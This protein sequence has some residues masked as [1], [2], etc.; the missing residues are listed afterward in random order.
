MKSAAISRFVMVAA[1]AALVVVAGSTAAWAQTPCPASPNYAT[2]F[3]SRP[4]C[5]QPNVNASVTTVLQLTANSGNQY[6]SAW[7]K[8]PQVVQNGFTTSFQFQFSTTT[9]PAD[10]IAF[11]IQNAGTGAIGSSPNGGA[12]GYGDSDN[13]ADPSQGAGIPHSLAIE[14]DSFHNGWDPATDPNDPSGNVSH[15]A[16]QSCGSGPNTSHH[17]Q[18]CNLGDNAPNSTVGAPVLVPALASTGSPVGTHT[19]TITYAPATG[20]TSANIHVMLD[21]HDL[22][23]GGVAVDLSSIGLGDGGTA[24]VGFTGATGG[25]HESQVVQNWTFTPQTQV[26]TQGQPAVYS[27][28]GGFDAGGFNYNAQLNTGNPVSVQVVPIPMT[29]GDCDNLVHATPAF[30]GAHCFV[31]DKGNGSAPAAVIFEITCPQSSGQKCNSLDALLGSDFNFTDANNPGVIGNLTPFPG[32]LKGDGLISGH[33]CA[34]ASPGAVVFNS[35]Q[36]DSFQI[37]AGDPPSKTKGGSG[38]TGS[39]WVA[40]YNQPDETLP[41][42]TF[43]PS[44]NTSYAQG[45]SPVVS[46]TC[47]NPSSSKLPELPASNPVGPYLTTA[48]CQQLSGSRISCSSPG[49]GGIACTGTLDTSTVGPHTFSVTAVDSGTNTNTQSVPYTVVAPADLRI[50]KSALSK[51]PVNSNLTYVITLVNRNSNPNPASA[52]G[53]VVTDPLPPNT[54]FVSAAGVNNLCTVTGG[55]LNC[56]ILPVSC[57]KVGNTVTCQVGTVGPAATWFLNGVAIQITVGVKNVGV[58]N[59]VKNTATVTETNTDPNGSDNSASASTTVT[60]H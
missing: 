37:L 15:V 1:I 34:Q 25:E 9:T 50:T 12:I 8:V 4:D 26:V 54:T 52:V 29:A 36:I 39:C 23:S 35:N 22:Y 3:S 38:G 49:L 20:T 30:H 5:V 21:G 14:F 40:T 41:T 19:V 43:V 45:T 6:G 16:I 24:F 44:A 51:I 59:T 11:V 13:N 33:P 42:V 55:R 31:Y 17:S 57:P 53:V 58:G 48:T 56:S 28:S 7:Y 27:S 2:D 10:G 60:A 32:W 46:Y 18:V 47:N